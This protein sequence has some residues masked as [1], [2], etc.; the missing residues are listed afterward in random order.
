MPAI[1]AVFS[2]ITDF[3]K[4]MGGLHGDFLGLVRRDIERFLEKTNNIYDQM[5][6][7]AWTT[8][9]LTTLSASMAIAGTLIPKGTSPSTPLDQRLGANNG[10]GDT[11][12][13]TLKWISEKLG[14]ND[15]LRTTC[16][17]TSKFFS[18]VGPAADALYGG[19]RT[20]LEASKQLLQTCYQEGQQQKG[21]FG[22]ETRKAQDAM[23]SIIQSKSRAN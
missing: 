10:I 9:G 11:V 22:S 23:L 4:T 2:T 20:K 17:T 19:A 12:S 1:D 8:V 21:L 18:S 3:S 16:K 13:N 6:W 14:D 5:Q 7:Q 15:F